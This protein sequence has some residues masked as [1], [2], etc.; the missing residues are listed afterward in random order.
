MK[1]GSFQI[2]C[3]SD[4]NLWLDGGAMF[5]VV[6]KALWN[7]STPCDGQNRIRLGTNCLLIRGAG[8]TL[9][10]D[11]GCGH[12]FSPQEARIYRI[13]HS[14]EL[15][16]QLE[17]CGVSADDVDIVINTHLHFDHSGTNTL[18]DGEALKAA[19]PNAVYLVRRDEH[20]A[21]THT[22]QRNASSYDPRNWQPLEA[23]GQLQLVEQEREVVPG[24]RLLHTPGHTLGHQSV[25]VSS[26]GKSLLYIADLCPTQAHVPLPWIMGY[27]L[28]PVTTLQTRQRVYRQAA[29]EEWAVFFEHDPEKVTGVLREEKGRYRVEN[30]PLFEDRTEN[31]A[32]RAQRGDA[33]GAEKTKERE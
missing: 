7:R 1:W 10:V 11:T 5:G 25:L 9:L 19:F 16:V 24:V 3:L 33:E 29:Q 26:Q 30:L 28:Y 32:Q 31:E 17:S 14:S 23:S 21:A 2:D 6:P 20:Q 27:D 22:H 15:L 8:K 4:G 13:Q 12:K 18:Q